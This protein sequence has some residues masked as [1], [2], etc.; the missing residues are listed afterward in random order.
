MDEVSSN[1]GGAASAP[2]NSTPSLAYNMDVNS[3]N[4][5][6]FSLLKL[7]RDST[8]D[9]DRAL[10]ALPNLIDSSTVRLLL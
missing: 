1:V 2:I 3:L 8:H 6:R 5:C 4:F 10:I 9:E 7:P